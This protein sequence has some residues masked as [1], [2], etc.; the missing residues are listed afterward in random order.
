MLLFALVL[1]Y[2]QSATAGDPVTTK[3]IEGSWTIKDVQV[4]N[5]KGKVSQCYLCDLYRNSTKLVF[6]ADGE[7]SYENN[8]NPTQVFYAVQNGKLAMYT[9][10]IPAAK[11]WTGSGTNTG[12]EDEPVYFG[13]SMKGNTLIMVYQSPGAGIT[14]TY[15]LTH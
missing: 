6:N 3:Q 5:I 2:V 9:A 10:A 11:L 14:E 15:T 1:F 7:V 4:S 8:N 12:K 13:L